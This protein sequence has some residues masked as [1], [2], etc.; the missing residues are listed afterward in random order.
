MQGIF[1]IVNVQFRVSWWFKAWS[2]YGETLSF[3]S[4]SWKIVQSTI[5]VGDFVPCLHGS[6]V[7]QPSALQ[8]YQFGGVDIG[9][10]QHLL[11][12]E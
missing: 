9:N 3:H 6:E 7:L 11:L 5:M 4:Y 10:R 12:I 1:L 8:F 2:N